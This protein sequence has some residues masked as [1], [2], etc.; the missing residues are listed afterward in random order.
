MSKFTVWLRD[1][2]ERVGITFATALLGIWLADDVINVAELG[3]LNAWETALTAGLT[4][5]GVLVLAAL[6]SLR[7]NRSSASLQSDLPLDQ[8]TADPK[9]GG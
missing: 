7:G 8:V 1:A 5:A 4:S 9:L 6:G 2:A 3:D